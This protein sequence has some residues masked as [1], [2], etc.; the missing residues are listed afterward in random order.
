MISK[1]NVN[2]MQKLHYSLRPSEWARDYGHEPCQNNMYLNIVHGW[3][4]F[5]RSDHDL[6]DKI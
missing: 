1:I 5:V 2:M 6:I 3:K 4:E